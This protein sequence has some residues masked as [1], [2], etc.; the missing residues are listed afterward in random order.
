MS[1]CDRD[2]LAL[3]FYRLPLRHH[4]KP[5]T[6]SVSG[7]SVAERLIFVPRDR[8][9]PVFRGRTGVELCEWVGGGGAGE[10]E[11]SAFIP[12]RPGV[13]PV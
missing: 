5:E 10:Y 3:V 2:R 13:F 9:C 12:V 4:Q 1:G 8:K 7:P 11:G 6:P